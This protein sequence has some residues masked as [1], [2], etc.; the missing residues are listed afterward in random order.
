MQPSLFDNPQERKY[1]FSVVKKLPYKFS[2]KIKDD[3][4]KES[5]PFLIIGVFYPPIQTQPTLF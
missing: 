4:G 3:D 5:T 2:Y 1:I